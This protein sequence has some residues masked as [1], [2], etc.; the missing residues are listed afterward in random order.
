MSQNGFV[1]WAQCKPN[2]KLEIYKIPDYRSF[3]V[4]KTLT[5]YQ[6]YSHC[7]YLWLQQRK[8]KRVLN[9]VHF[10]NGWNPIASHLRRRMK[11]VKRL[12]LDGIQANSSIKTTGQEPG[13]LAP[14]GSG[15][16]VTRSQST[17]ELQLSPKSLWKQYKEVSLS[18]SVVRPATTWKQNAVVWKSHRKQ[19]A[20]EVVFAL[21]AE[22]NIRMRQRNVIVRVYV[23]K[24]LICH[25]MLTSCGNKAFHKKRTTLE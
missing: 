11:T 22:S 21:H 9:K 7:V 1:F 4:L 17:Q 23:G 15:I 8:I 25:T 20:S 18:T 10:F 19:C 13:L 24:W 16:T 3:S 2:A 14:G 5:G 6:P 12:H